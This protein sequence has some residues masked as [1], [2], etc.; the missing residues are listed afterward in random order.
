MGRAD[1]SAKQQAAKML[2][3]TSNVD[4][5][6]DADDNAE[7]DNV[8]AKPATKNANEASTVT[9]KELEAMQGI[10]KHMYEF[11]TAEGE[12]PSKLFH[13]KVNRRFLP[14]YYNVIKEP[15]AMSTIKAKLNTREYQSFEEFVRDW[16]LICHNAQ[17]YNSPKA[18]A[19]VN[20]MVI[21]V[22]VQEELYKLAEKG[23]VEKSR[24]TLPF[25]GEIPPAEEVL[26]QDEEE[27]DD[28]DDEEE[29]EE[30]DSEDDGKKK[31]R[32][33][34]R[35]SLGAKR[36]RESKI[37]EGKEKDD[38]PDL[39]KKRGRPPRVDTPL[40][41]RIK[42]VLKGLRKP[43]NSEG[44]LLVL[45]FERVPDKAEVPDYFTEIKNPIAMDGIKRKLKR[46]KY[47][48]VDQFMRDVDL[49]FNNAKQYNTDE[50]DVYRYANELQREAH[51]LAEQEKNKPDTEFTMEDGRMPLPQGILHNGEVWR[52]GKS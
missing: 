2:P 43:R 17:L 26:A 42:A 19:Y 28:D 23:V 3:H 12:D 25:M 32:K 51:S 29:D 9:D 7:D 49:M 15:M 41:A 47:T 8:D 1:S 44:E 10:L 22:V 5:T 24:V 37:V 34:G 4:S 11:R 45:N 18:L 30:E 16:A 40:E 33:R 35:P 46:K 20:A 48:S 50:S 39:R 21:K 36:E 13:R 6:A 38:D 52:V 31:Q 14:D 27:D